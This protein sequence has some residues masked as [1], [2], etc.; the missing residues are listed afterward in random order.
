MSKFLLIGKS[1]FRLRDYLDEHG[2][3][4]ITLLDE[5]A[6]KVSQT[7]RTVL[8]DFSSIDKMIATSKQ[9]SEKG[10]IDGVL[11]IYE[12]Y[13]LPA[14]YIAKSLGV[15]AL[16][17]SAAEACTDKEL[18]REKFA[19]APEK[20]SPDF[21]V[22]KDKESLVKF[23]NNHDFPLILK[24]A[25]LAKSLLVT[26]ANNQ[27]ELLAEYEQTMSQIVAVYDKYAPFRKP[28]LLVEE[29]I[30]GSIHS[31][32]AFIDNEGEVEVLKEVV[33]YE[34]GQ[35]IGHND[36]FHYSRLLPSRLSKSDIESIRHTAS[37]GCKALGM[38][39]SP[40]HVEIILS[41]NGPRIVEI[42]ARNGGYRERMHSIANGIDLTA[43]Q[44]TTALGKK[45]DI[46]AK[47]NDS[48][49]VLE[50]FPK[51]EGIFKEISNR[52]NLEKLESLNYFN[53]KAKPGQFVGKSSKGYKACAVIILHNTD[54]NKFNEDFHFVRN[55]VLVQTLED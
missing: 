38:A 44:L 7:E 50:L 43:A 11:A 16:P 2:H 18:M 31:V 9:I 29:F 40:A 12:N 6:K 26:K 17:I 4:Y 27:E 28:K 13:I 3:S 53:P 42:G 34:T 14:A 23:A 47:R 25:N 21:Q 33:D 32:D 35:D 54:K 8:C 52:Q 45:P 49:V 55:N 39:N 51:N 10:K 36:N 19:L 37:V 41:K 24:P 22:V 46:T 20:I 48:C 15:P 30:E 1:F 5:K